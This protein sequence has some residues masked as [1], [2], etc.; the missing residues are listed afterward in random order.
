[1]EIEGQLQNL[2]IEEGNGKGKKV[3]SPMYEELL[4]KRQTLPVWAKSQEILDAVKVC[5]IKK[6]I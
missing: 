4:K 2:K 3:H 5:K 6:D 1:M